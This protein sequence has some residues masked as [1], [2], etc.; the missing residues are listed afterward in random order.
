LA[1]FGEIA[2]GWS[3]RGIVILSGRPMYLA[4]AYM[5]LCFIRRHLK[6]E[7]PVEVWY[8]GRHERN[9][10]MFSAIGSLGGVK[11]VDAHEVQRIFPMKPNTMGCVHKGF[12]PA[13]TEGWR[14]KSYCLLHSGFREVISLDSDCFLFQKPEFLLHEFPPYL[15]TGAVFSADIDTAPD[16]PRLVNPTTRIVSRLGAYTDREWDYSRPNPMWGFLGLEEDDLPEF[17]SGFMMVDKGRNVDAVFASFYLNDESDFV[18]RYLYGDKDTFH[19][20][21][22]FCRSPCH[23]IRD[24]SRERDHIVGR[25]MGA[26][27]FEHRVFTNKFDIEKE[28]DQSPNDNSFYM[29]EE[30]LEYFNSAKKHSAL[31]IF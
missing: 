11:F 29:R 13:S 12:A 16:T 7:L 2:E 21:W 18:Y 19:L 23:V 24:V 1:D 5:N 8:L 28:W 30:F 14:T 27:L 10:R 20:A 25:A 6:C 15:N 26:T 3:G 22:S 31:K 4:N 9:E 17:E